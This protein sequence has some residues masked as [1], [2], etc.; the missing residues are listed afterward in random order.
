M[1]LKTLG[2]SADRGTIAARP[3]RP[4]RDRIGRRGKE[5]W[6]PGFFRILKDIREWKASA[7]AEAG[8]QSHASTRS[9]RTNPGEDHRSDRERNEKPPETP[10][11]SSGGA[12]CELRIERASK[13]EVSVR[14]WALRPRAPGEPGSAGPGSGESARRRLPEPAW[15]A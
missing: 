3:L 4:E 11:R 15:A 8:G 13:L 10:G 2:E 14:P 1:T 7:P 12:I 6:L 5:R 9:W